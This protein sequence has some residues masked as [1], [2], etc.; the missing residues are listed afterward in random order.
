M[1]TYECNYDLPLDIK[2]RLLSHCFDLKFKQY[3]SLKGTEVGLQ[4]AH[5]EDD[6]IKQLMRKLINKDIEI[7]LCIFVK[8]MPNAMIED[9]IDDS[10]LRRSCITWALA[11]SLDKFAPVSYGNQK[12]YYT[13]KP[14]ILNTQSEHRMDNNQFER[15]SFQLCLSEDISVLAELD[16]TNQLFTS[17]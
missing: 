15:Y 16:Q 14:L 17:L 5:C 3:V 13:A 12:T 6:E 4:S 10:L 7:N 9:H 1:D 8:F 2:Y 11:P